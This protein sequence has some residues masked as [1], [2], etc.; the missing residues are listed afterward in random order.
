MSWHVIC[1]TVFVLAAIPTVMGLI[2]MFLYRVPPKPSGRVAPVSV[3]VPARDEEQRIRPTIESVLTSQDIE[4]EL[5]VADDHS[6]DG[7][8]TLVVEYAARDNRVKLLHVPDLP[9]GWSGKMHACHFLS[10]HARHEHM[11]FV[12]ADVIVSVDALCRLSLALEQPKNAMVS[13]LPRQIMLSFWEKI[14]IPQIHVLL[15][16]Y[17]P[18]IGM[19]LSTWAAFGAGCGQ[20]LGVRKSDYEECDG[21]EAIRHLIHD[22]LQLSRLFRSHGKG[23]DMVDLTPMA[24]TRMYDNVADIWAG[25]LKNAHEGIATPIALPI[26]TLLLVGGHIAPYILLIIA[27]LAGYPAELP[28]IACM[29]VIAFRVFMGW[30][31]QIPLISAL[32][33]PLGVGVMM[34]LQ[35]VA[36]FGA[37]RGQQ[38]NW[39]GRGYTP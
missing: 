39:R 28:L 30:K 25:F 22:A 29:M 21:H 23:T 12:D 17:L 3:L 20:L 11:I 8:A 27:L 26:W 6:T 1:V 5:L 15:L 33:H 14:L 10:Q 38:I 32:L 13:G 16:G 7:T 36:L 18:F 9:E 24:A 4:L 34:I 31:Y 19:R 35:W 37:A 2:N